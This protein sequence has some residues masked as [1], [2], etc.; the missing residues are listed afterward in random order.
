MRRSRL[1]LVALIIGA[2]C[3]AA[4][5]YQDVN[6]PRKVQVNVPLPDAA[7]ADSVTTGTGAFMINGGDTRGFIRVKGTVTIGAGTIVSGLS[8]SGNLWLDVMSG[9]TAYRIDSVSASALPMTLDVFSNDD[10]LMAGKMRISYLIYDTTGD[11][12]GDTAS[13]PIWWDLRLY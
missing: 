2:L 12:A 9:G 3:V 4:G 7:H 11:T 1:F 8:D 6:A 10:S 13:Y 5:E